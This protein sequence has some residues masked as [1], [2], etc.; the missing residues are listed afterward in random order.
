MLN[1]VQS[2]SVK[3]TPYGIWTNKEP[4]LSHLKIWGYL[5]YRKRTLSDKLEAKYD[6][7]LFVG[8]P[9]EVLDISSTTLKNKICLFQSI[10]SS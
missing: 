9:K 7:C 1:K 6:R 4:Y 5:D 2:K 10:Q 3:V 8:Y